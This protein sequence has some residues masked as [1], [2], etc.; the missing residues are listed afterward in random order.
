[1]NKKLV[2]FLTSIFI[3]G[4]IAMPVEAKRMKKCNNLKISRCKT[5]GDC[6]WVKRHAKKRIVVKAHCRKCMKKVG[7]KGN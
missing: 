2:V 3:A 1:M 4:L 5:R 7:C 6:K